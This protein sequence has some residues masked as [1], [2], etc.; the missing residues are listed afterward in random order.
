MPQPIVKTIAE[1]VHHVPTLLAAGFP[2][3]RRG[4]GGLGVACRAQS[5]HRCR[6]RERKPHFWE[7]WRW[8]GRQRPLQAGRKFRRVTVLQAVGESREKVVGRVHGADNPF[9]HGQSFRN[10]GAKHFGNRWVD[11]HLIVTTLFGEKSRIRAD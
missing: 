9:V 10:G 2:P 8:V 1:P 3:L 11:E 7:Q 6:P 5:F 4:H